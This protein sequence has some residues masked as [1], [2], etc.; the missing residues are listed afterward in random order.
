MSVKK[1]TVKSISFAAVWIGC[2][3]DI[4]D[5]PSCASTTTSS[6]ANM[7]DASILHKTAPQAF[8]YKLDTFPHRGQMLLMENLREEVFQ[9]KRI[10]CA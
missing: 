9:L 3:R 1:G 6:N 5:T 10:L 2:V 7:P 8:P 4:Q